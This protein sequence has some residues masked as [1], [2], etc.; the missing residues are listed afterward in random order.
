LL[1]MPSPYESLSIVLLEAWGMGK[2]VLVN[3]KCDV[4]VGQ[5]RRAQGGLWYTSKD[6]FQVAIEKMDELVRNQLGLQG[7][8][9]VELNY[10]WSVIESLY[11][12]LF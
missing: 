2:S 9:F 11:L 8:S 3:G 10:V 12:S 7:K 6:E 4:L 1:V 5:C